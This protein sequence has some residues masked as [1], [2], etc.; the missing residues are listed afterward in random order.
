MRPEPTAEASLPLGAP[1]KA[2]PAANFSR[3]LR[4]NLH[5][6]LAL[7]AGAAL[8]E[9]LGWSLGLQWLPPFSTVMKASN[10]FSASASK[11]PF[12][13]PAQPRR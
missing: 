3:A 11:S 6:L 13:M 1:K 10:S 2:L 5:E 7:L 4:D 8:W 12:L 9:A